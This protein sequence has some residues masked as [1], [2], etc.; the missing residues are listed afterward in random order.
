MQ[1]S[2]DSLSGRTSKGDACA[3][4]IEISRVDPSSR[5]P[6]ST[7]RI[8]RLN[9][10]LGNHIALSLS[11]FLALS[12]YPHNIHTRR[13]LSNQASSKYY[14]IEEPP[15]IISSVDAS[16]EEYTRLRRDI[17]RDTIQDPTPIRTKTTAVKTSTV[18]TLKA[19]SEG[20][21]LGLTRSNGLV[22]DA[23]TVTFIMV[24]DK[25][26]GA[27]RIDKFLK[28]HTVHTI[29]DAKIQG[30]LLNHKLY[31]FD[32]VRGLVCLACE[33]EDRVVLYPVPS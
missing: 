3:T 4:P 28:H 32:K 8:E 14:R 33:E 29:V 20:K 25:S 13:Y 15:T 11:T 6:M 12:H 19:N 1:W 17:Y 27:Q 16:L 5:D 30:E 31:Y 24:N 21:T 9:G 10:H 23:N 2:L 26:N 22:V 7:H 18:K